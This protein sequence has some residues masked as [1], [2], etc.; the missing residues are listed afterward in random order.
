MIYNL[1]TIGQKEFVQRLC[2]RPKQFDMFFP[3]I[4]KEIGCTKL[5]HTGGGEVSKQIPF[6]SKVQSFLGVLV[7][8][9]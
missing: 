9:V 2:V 8:L 5:K 6:L 7:N 3:G 1:G 4:D